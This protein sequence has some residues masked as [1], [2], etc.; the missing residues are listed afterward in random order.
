MGGVI[1][2][3]MGGRKSSQIIAS[4]SVLCSP[5]LLGLGGIYSMNSFDLLFWAALFYVLIKIINTGDGKLWIWFGV[6]AGLGLMNKIS[7]G[8]FGAGLVISM[9]LTKERKWFKNKY[10][11]LGGLI[12]LV[13]FSPYIIWNFQNDFATLEFIRNASQYK[14]A[15]IGFSGF[16][17]EQILQ[18][19][20]LNAVIWITGLIALLVTGKLSKYRV[21]AIAFIA[22]F[23]ILVLNNGKPYYLAAAFISLISAGS[24][25][26]TEFFLL[27]KLKFLTPVYSFLFLQAR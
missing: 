11:W 27:R 15:Q 23:A 6:I 1:A 25:T 3:S 13:I 9:A 10:F 21:I 19:N 8:Y 12:A 4:I 18:M 26:I 22:V 24:I 16:L 7:V 5:V 14:N 17:K 20:P 2:A